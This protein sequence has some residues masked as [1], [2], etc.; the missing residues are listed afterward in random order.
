MPRNKRAL[1]LGASG[2]T[3]GHLLRIL[4]ADDRYDHI[5][6]LGRKPLSLEHRKLQQA[7]IDFDHSNRH[8]GFFQV[9]EVFCCLG[10]TINKAGSREN[11][12]KVDH[13]YPLECARMAK[14]AGARSFIIVTSLGAHSRSRNF[15]LRTKGSL[16]EELKRL[17]FERLIIVRPSLL[18][19]ERHERRLLE[20][21]GIS[22]MPALAFLLVGPLR[23]YRAI[24]AEKVAW[25]MVHLAHTVT[26]PSR[27]VESDELDA[28]FKANHS[29]HELRSN[30]HF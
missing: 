19:G 22:M 13:T 30:S 16:E 18:L 3:G 21:V 15:Y 25:C 8:Q 4:L 29:D 27:I 24:A 12:F 2:L 28:M 7:V 1:L 17:N 9:D 11:F 20:S 26:E 6:T 23:Q 14:G 10:T 5:T